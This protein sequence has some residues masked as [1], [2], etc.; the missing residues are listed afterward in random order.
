MSNKKATKR[1]LLTSITALAMCVVML[2]GTTFAWFTDTATA[3][4][5]KIQAGKLDVA[6]EMKDSAGNW[7][8]AEGK[9]LNFV[10]AAGGESQAI[11]WEPGA[12]YKLPELR[13]RNDGNLALKY[14]VAI[15]GAVDATP[16]NGVNDLE[17]L[18]VITFSASIGGGT[19]PSGV[20]GKTIATGALNKNGDFQTIQLSAKMDENAGN[21]YQEMAIS[22]IAITVKAMQ[23]SYEY[24]SNGNTYDD[25][26]DMTPDNLD[27]RIS[28]NVTV[29]V[30]SS[31]DTKISNADK[32]AVA[33]VP[34]TAVKDSSGELTLKV[35]A[36]D[37]AAANVSIN[38]A[39]AA[40][41]YEVEVVGLDTTNTAPVKVELKVGAGLTNVVLYH[42][43]NPMTKGTS[44][45]SLTDGQYF[46]NEST[47]VLTFAT[48]T[49]SPFAVVYDAPTAV[50]GDTYYDTL[51][52]AVAAAQDGDT[53]T[54]LKNTNG[55]GI[56]VAT[57]KFATRGLTVNFNGH[58]YTVGGVLVGSP[59]TGTNAFQLLQGGK[60]TFKNGSIVGVAEGTKPA[61]DTPDWKGA[62]AIVL[63]N[64]CNLVLDNMIVT[65]GDETVYT[66]SN[67]CGDI[68][69]NNT[70]I[71]AGKAQ[72][73]KDGPYAFDVYGGFQSYGNVTVKVDGNSVINGDIEV[74]HGDRAK[75]NNANTLILGDCTINGNILKSD[76]TLNFAGNVTL[77]GNV[78][79]TKNKDDAANR[80]IVTGAT[81]L[82][83][84][85]KIITPNNMGNNNTNFT[86]LI[87][88]ADTAI[89]AGVNGGID[90][91]TNGG[92]A[93]NV[94]NGATLT[95]NGGTYYGG[96][97]AVQVQKGTLVINDGTFEV[98]PYSDPTYGYKFL[99][100]C[101]DAAYKDGT[102]KIMV[103]GGSFVNY[104]PSD[105]ASENPRGNFV[106]E[107]YSCT[108]N[109]GVW[110]V[111]KNA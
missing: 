38:S 54:L 48:S 63:Q 45:D 91:Q 92:Y 3:N 108:E 69:I 103:R 81:T 98:E 64:Y 4:V 109:N 24:D 61:E 82:N 33:T 21:K 55:N 90:T 86:A 93:I 74:A 110:T 5:N 23:T 9:T 89:N 11:L 51:A 40:L 1:A 62:P 70:T 58:S 25:A 46:Y 13:V 29:P 57:E 42:N 78:N 99:I 47:G 37:S 102:A 14:E 49:F 6:L 105:S 100:N 96:G 80:I 50:I 104:D 87:V 12:E 85:G 79:V 35:A 8:T 34:E 17:L 2:V 28:A 65:G 19:A 53:I 68:V 18:N 10:K 60:I 71:N 101:I 83:L 106:D 111:T 107:G 84:N 43:G 73:Y 27:K 30:A 15:T 39:Q 77:N 41:G 88:D 31:G 32:T 95:I 56:Q 36:D 75:N 20:Y 44:A 94:R 22:G 97:T 7:V 72:G 67:N 52:D 26:A 66:M 76:G 16:N 59:G